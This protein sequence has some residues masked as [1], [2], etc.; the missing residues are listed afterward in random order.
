MSDGCLPSGPWNIVLLCLQG[1][2]P[3]L[4][5]SVIIPP[6]Q[7]SLCHLV[8]VGMSPFIMLVICLHMA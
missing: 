3:G 7:V 6:L 2:S 4:Y 5:G 8:I 1:P